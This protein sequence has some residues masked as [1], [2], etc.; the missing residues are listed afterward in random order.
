MLPLEVGDRVVCG[1]LSMKDESPR[2]GEIVEVYFGKP[3]ATGHRERMM[4]VRWDDNGLVERG[5][6]DGGRLRR[7]PI[8]VPTAWVNKV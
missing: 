8:C 1:G 7:E 3:S 5:Y 6:L 2:H 4:A